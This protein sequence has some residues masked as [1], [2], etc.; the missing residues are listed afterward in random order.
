MMSA[1]A[2][3]PLVKLQASAMVAQPVGPHRPPDCLAL[4]PPCPAPLHARPATSLLQEL[5]AHQ[6]PSTRLFLCSPAGLQF[7]HPRIPLALQRHGEG[8]LGL[9]QLY[10]LLLPVPAYYAT[11]HYGGLLLARLIEFSSPTQRQRLVLRLVPR[12]AELALHEEGHRAVVGLLRHSGPELQLLLV[13]ELGRVEGAALCCCGPGSR[14][15]QEAVKA[16]APSSD[17]RQ[18]LVLLAGRLAGIA[19]HVAMDKYGSKVT[20]ARPP[21]SRW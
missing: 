5:P 12:V 16:T 10:S 2:G 8:G 15:V 9:E 4:P 13:R 11:T 20:P 7:L 3:A 21:L 17:A 18:E 6:F 1:P 19:L 14:V